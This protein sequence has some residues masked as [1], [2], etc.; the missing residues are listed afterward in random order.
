MQDDELQLPDYLTDCDCSQQPCRLSAAV[1]G[2]GIPDVRAALYLCWSI[3]FDFLL[4]KFSRELDAL[5]ETHGAVY[6]HPAM[7]PGTYCASWYSQVCKQPRV[8][9]CCV[10]D[11]V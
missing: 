6:C 5:L 10:Q 2:A 1:C 3:V 7:S 9:Y 11:H 4:G 8:P